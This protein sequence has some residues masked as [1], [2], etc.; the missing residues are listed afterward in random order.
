MKVYV[1]APFQ[2]IE[3][4]RTISDVLHMN[5]IIVVSTWPDTTVTDTPENWK[6]AAAGDLAELDQAHIL[7]AINSIEWGNKGTGG[8][9]VELGYALARRIPVLLYGDRTHAFHYDD[10]VTHIDDPGD[11]VKALHRI[12]QINYTG[13]KI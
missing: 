12:Y 6:R 8:R 13:S 10:S 11:F 1:S 3:K 9:H 7:L 4:A 2:L 5:R